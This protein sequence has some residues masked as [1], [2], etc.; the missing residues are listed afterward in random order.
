MRKMSLA[1]STI[2]LVACGASA[3][4]ASIHPETTPTML[5]AT[6]TIPITPTN[7]LL[8]PSPTTQATLTS[9]IENACVQTIEKFVQSGPCT[10]EHHSLIY[11]NS[12]YFPATPM[13]TNDPFCNLGTKTILNVMPADEW[14][15]SIYP[16]QPIP[17]SAKPTLPN[18]Y[19][20]RVLYEIQWQP[21]VVPAGDNPFG[22]FMWMIYDADTGT[23]LVNEYGN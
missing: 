19:V 12:R 11:P 21:G 7:T 6:P 15:H 8:R 9:E 13:A 1:L 10:D 18:E 20:F 3:C 16:N 23:C 2:I 4:S 17:E 14:W 5:Q 22:M